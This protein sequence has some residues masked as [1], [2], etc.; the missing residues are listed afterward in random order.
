MG[1]DANGLRLMDQSDMF[2]ELSG[3][4]EEVSSLL[5]IPKEAANI[6]LR[7][8]KFNKEKLIEQF[9]GDKEAVTEAAG[10]RWRCDE[11]QGGDVGGGVSPKK[12]GGRNK[13]SAAS[14]YCR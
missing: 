12:K 7:H 8:Y 2:E 4:L 1:K 9:Y 6:L 3:I 13:A 5:H 10:V 11:L 14:V